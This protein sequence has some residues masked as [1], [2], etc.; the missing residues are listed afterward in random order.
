MK[1]RPSKKTTVRKTAQKAGEKAKYKYEKK[2]APKKPE[3][4]GVFSSSRRGFG[5][6]TPND[7]GP[8]TRDIFIPARYVGTAIDGD[9]VAYT[10]NPSTTPDRG[11]DGAITRI[12]SRGKTA[13][14]GTFRV[15]TDAST[16]KTKKKYYV[17]A[18]DS[19]LC[20]DTLLSAADCADAKDGDKVLCGIKRYPDITNELPAR[21]EIIKVYGGAETLFANYEALLDEHGVKTEFDTDTLAFADKAA[22]RPISPDGRLDLR[23]KPIFT[24]DGAGAKDLDDAVSVEKTDKGWRL[25]VH[26]AD[27]SD[28]VTAGSPTDNEAFERG[29]SIY[30]TDKVVP[31]L[32]QSLSNGACSLNAGVDRL[33]L[34]AFMDIDV[35]GNIIDCDIYESIINSKVRGVYSEVNDIIEAYR[36]GYIENSEYYTKYQ[37][38]LGGGQLGVILSLYETLLAKGKRKGAL[39]LDD[40]EAVILLNEDGSVKDIV[41]VNRGD[42]ERLIEQFMLAANEGVANRLF[43][44]DLPCVYRIH[45]Q[46][47]EDKVTGLINFAFS[48][49][50]DVKPLKK[51]RPTSADFQRLLE[52]AKEKGLGGVLSYVLLRS[53]MKAKYSDAPSPHFG[54]AIDKYCHFTSPIRRYPDLS[55]HRIVKAALLRKAD[56]AHISALR[57]FAGKS[58]IQSSEAE[59]NALKAERDIEDLYKTLF[60]K[61]KEGQEFDGVISSVLPTGLFVALE[62]TCEG[63][64][65]LTRLGKPDYSELT[66]TVSCCGKAYP[67]GSPIRIK[68][69]TADIP[70]RKIDFELCE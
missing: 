38:V 52:Q 30:F 53:M 59:Q 46:P 66:Q 70:T 36:A 48:L 43:N 9:T 69:V 13:F 40:R 34:S 64:V 42:G 47:A 16:G 28:Y 19:K 61:S 51:E 6:V 33:T 45:E 1:K 18:D 22:S 17:I 58:G 50:L 11:D 23:D 62:N 10:V 44:A 20:F 60:M 3:Y 14:T 41:P 49:G 54:L 5:F 31:M 25:G 26:I 29:T 57:T 8:L 37:S 4:E 63:F 56:K 27:V 15:I 24:I 67:L 21:G 35:R 68:V 39:E 65:S 32:P 55:V 12:I 2:S 7:A